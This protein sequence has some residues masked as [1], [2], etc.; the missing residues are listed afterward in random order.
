MNNSSYGRDGGSD[1]GVN[2]DSFD[3]DSE[4]ESEDDDSDDDDDGVLNSDF[5]IESD[6]DSDDD[7]DDV[8]VVSFPDREKGDTLDQ[9]ETYQRVL[10]LAYNMCALKFKAKIRLAVILRGKNAKVP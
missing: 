7:D 3:S 9:Q 2:E 5:S 1:G 6:D 8:V 4:Y 10:A